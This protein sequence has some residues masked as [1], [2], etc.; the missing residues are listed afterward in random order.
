MQNPTEPR[1]GLY[2]EP[3]AYSLK[4]KV[5]G[6][7]SAGLAFL[8]AVAGTRPERLWCYAAGREAAVACAEAMAEHG[9]PRTGIHFVPYTHP[10]RLAEAG[11]LYRPDPGIAQDAWRRL[12]RASPDAYSLCGITHTTASHAV[13]ET[14]A[15]LPLAPL[16]SW[17]AL[18]CTSRAVRDSVRVLVE[19]QAEYLRERVGATRIS[20]PQLPVIP[21][22]VHV[23]QFA[24]TPDARAR[25]RAALGLAQDEVAVLFAGR[26]SFHGKAHPVPMYLGLE[27][28]ARDARIVLI[29]AG[30]FANDGIEQAFKADAAALCPSVR[31]LY[32][33]GR[34][35]DRLREAFAASDLFTSLSD[36]VQET[37]GLT[38]LEA[39]AAGLPCVVTDWDGYR[40]TVRDGID[41]FRVPTAAP[42]PGTTGDLADRFDLGLDSYDFYCG[43]TSQLV[44]VD[45]PAAAR[46]YGA[47]IRDAELRA[48]MGAA[49]Q[50]H[51]RGAFDW[52][53]IF[54]RYLALWDEL[55]ERRRSEPRLSPPLARRRR[56]EREDPFTVFG[57]YPSR[58]ADNRLQFRRID[59]AETGVARRA[60][61]TTSFAG[62]VLPAP[63][64]VHKLCAALPEGVARSSDALAGELRL[65]REQVARAAL[66]LT[67]VGVLSFE[68]A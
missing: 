6:R 12:N 17:D 43:L 35:Q 56:P 28:N 51:A 23:D 55:G 46:A 19:G 9:S 45:V 44:A 5:M 33:D 67:K 36:N 22:G 57:G 1:Y 27:A 54:Q 62:L 48:R 29:Q 25:A 4:G 32:V 20:L 50:A 41:G 39:M 13:M 10:E 60:L 15:G 3:S 31:C 58:T 26:L 21:L 30:W 2:F 64:L 14:L 53:V 38:P 8:R 65:P 16:E 47:L 24:R 11:L 42:A 34:D 40:D 63:D 66:W 52:S 37:F 49:A 68:E 61:Q 59:S 18:I 7:Q